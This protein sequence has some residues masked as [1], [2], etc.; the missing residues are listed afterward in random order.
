MTVV[1][2]D[3]G[4]E[5][6]VWGRLGEGDLADLL[7]APRPAS[8]DLTMPR[9]ETRSPAMLKAPLMAAGMPTAFGLEADFSGMTGESDLFI[10]SVVHEGWIAVDETGTEAAAA[11][12][13]LMEAQSAGPPATEVA[14]DRPFLYCIH[15]VAHGTPLFVGWVDDPSV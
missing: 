15:D 4:A 6:A 14:L 2:P 13:V 12:A 1:L 3:A 7:A 5:S 11:T 8:V 9:W 10:G